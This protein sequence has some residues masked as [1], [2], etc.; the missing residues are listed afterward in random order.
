MDKLMYKKPQ[1]S[2]SVDETELPAIKNWEVGKTY[3]PI[4]G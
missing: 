4:K 3:I 1:P 2:I